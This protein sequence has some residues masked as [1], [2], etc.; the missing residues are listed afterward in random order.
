MRSAR[1]G[2]PRFDQLLDDA[3]I[4]C[5]PTAPFPAP[6][7]GLPRSVM[8]EKRVP[9]ITLTSIAGM[10][11][12]PQ[13]SMPLGEVDGLPVGLSIMGRARQR[14]HAARRRLGYEGSFA[15]LSLSA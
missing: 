4:V 12:T 5:L 8:W 7:R 14:R 13:L 15:A 1:R 11:G 3:T 9:V 6:L 10:L 2:A